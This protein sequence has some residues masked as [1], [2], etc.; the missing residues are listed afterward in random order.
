MFESGNYDLKHVSAVENMPLSDTLSVRAAFDSAI[1]DGYQTSGADAEDELGARISALYEPNNDFTAYRWY[2]YNHTGGQPANTV[3]L[4]GNHQ[5]ADPEKSVGNDYFC[6]PSGAGAPLGAVPTCDP[7]YI[8]QQSQ[9]FRTN[10]F[11]GQFDWH[12]QGASGP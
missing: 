12:L 2:G 6:A 5:F 10:L 11:G 4:T 7:F 9:D 3:T 8:G 1:H